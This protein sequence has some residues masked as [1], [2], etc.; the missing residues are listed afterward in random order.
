VIVGTPEIKDNKQGEIKMSSTSYFYLRNDE[1]NATIAYRRNENGTVSYGV[2]FC[3]PTD[4]FVKA[5]GRKIAEGRMTNNTFFV[6]DAPAER[7]N[8]HERIINSIRESRPSYA[9]RRFVA[10]S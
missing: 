5:M 1:Y 10:R 9:P 8:L 2:S 7:W 3:R 4:P 6:T